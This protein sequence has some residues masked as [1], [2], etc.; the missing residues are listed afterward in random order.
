MQTQYLSSQLATAPTWGLAIDSATE[1]YGNAGE[2]GALFFSVYTCLHYRIP[3]A[4][5]LFASAFASDTT[6]RDNIIKSVYNHAN[7]N[8]SVGVFPERY[9]VTNNAANNGRAG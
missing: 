2:P 3:S 7:F 1:P 5:S 9:N 8:Q 6:V 4:W